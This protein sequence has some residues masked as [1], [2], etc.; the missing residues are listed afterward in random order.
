VI[1][2]V[3]PSEKNPESPIANGAILQFYKNLATANGWQV[4]EL[5]SKLYEKHTG[6]LVEG[7]FPVSNAVLR[8][9]GRDVYRKLFLESGTHRFIYRDEH[10]SGNTKSTAKTHTSYVQSR[11]YP[12]PKARAFKFNESDV[13]FSFTRSSGPGGQHVNKTDSAVHAVHQPTGIA[14]FVQQERSQHRNKELAIEM[15]KAKVFSKYL[16]EEN[17]RIERHKSRSDISADSSEN[18]YVRTYNFVRSPRETGALLRGD[19]ELEAFSAWRAH[20][21]GALSLKTQELSLEIQELSSKLPQN[22]QPFSDLMLMRMNTKT[23]A[24]SCKAILN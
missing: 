16:E 13:T 3:M 9:S 4:E 2:E 14:V 21:Q 15:L 10:K 19:I 20:M 22:S 5:S 7:G 8:I 17:L 6:V 24:G 1:V 23:Q 11:I 12:K 18:P